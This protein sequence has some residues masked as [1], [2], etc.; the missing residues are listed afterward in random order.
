MC[1][2]GLR[3]FCYTY[4]CLLFLLPYVSCRRCISPLLKTLCVLVSSITSWGN[5]PTM[6]RHSGICSGIKRQRRQCVTRSATSLLI[7][8]AISTSPSATWL[9]G[10]PRGAFLRSCWKRRCSRLGAMVE[11][12]SS[13]M[14][15]LT[16]CIFSFR[17]DS[18]WLHIDHF[19]YIFFPSQLACHKVFH[20]DWKLIFGSFKS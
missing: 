17:A 5:Q 20:F 4:S 6:T 11:L 18:S 8:V 13:V 3:L 14:V 1:A 16:I 15:R 2:I 9:I 19:F 12:L 10:H 7:V